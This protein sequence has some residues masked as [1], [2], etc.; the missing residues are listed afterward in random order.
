MRNDIRVTICGLVLSGTAVVIAAVVAMID[1]FNNGMPW[2]NW[3]TLSVVSVIAVAFT[4]TNA[5]IVRSDDKWL[6][7]YHAAS[8][9]FLWLIPG[10]VIVAMIT[11]SVQPKYDSLVWAA[12]SIPLLLLPIT[13]L[14]QYLIVVIANNEG[15]GHAN[16]RQV[17]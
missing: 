1:P 16:L 7:F 9:F 13:A 3:L 10:S 2:M 12:W 4:T 6:I 5:I 17:A 14:A 15:S 11:D 8:A